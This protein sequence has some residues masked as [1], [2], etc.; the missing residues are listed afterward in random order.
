MLDVPTNN[1]QLTNGAGYQTATQV[2]AA[3]TTALQ[4]FQTINYEIVTTLPTTGKIGTIYLIAKSGKDKDVY[5][6]YIYINN[7]FE[8]IGTTAADLS[9]YW[10]KTDIVALTNK[11]IDAAIALA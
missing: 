7:K 11:E 10:T 8:L 3:I 9:N 6:E 4:N 2:N 1:N 5:N